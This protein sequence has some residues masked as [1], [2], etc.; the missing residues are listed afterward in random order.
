MLVSC[1]TLPRA[2]GTSLLCNPFDFTTP[3]P[4]TVTL[5]RVQLHQQN[6]SSYYYACGFIVC[7]RNGRGWS[8]RTTALQ[9]QQQQPPQQVC[10]PCMYCAIWLT[11]LPILCLLQVSAGN[12]YESLA[13]MA[14]PPAVI[15]PPNLSPTHFISSKPLNHSIY[16]ANISDYFVQKWALP[17]CWGPYITPGGNFVAS[18]SLHSSQAP[19]PPPHLH[20]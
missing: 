12:I 4:I 5:M 6:C 10:I 13:N 3:L 11:I 9:P 14:T 2:L 8:Y 16:Y 1:C 7:L 19:P 17:V 15:T 18:H 20:C